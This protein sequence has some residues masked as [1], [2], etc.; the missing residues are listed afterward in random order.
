MTAPPR[1]A[2]GLW[3]G[4]GYDAELARDGAE[5]LGDAVAAFVV[6]DGRIRLLADGLV[7]ALRAAG[8][9]ERV[10]HGVAE[11][12]AATVECHADE[13]LEYVNQ[14]L[15]GGGGGGGGGGVEGGGV[16]GGA[17]G[18]NVALT[19]VDVLDA[20]LT[21]GSEG[22]FLAAVAGWGALSAALPSVHSQPSAADAPVTARLCGDRLPVAVRTM[23]GRVALPGDPA[24]TA[25]VLGDE[26]AA[27]EH[28]HR[29][30][31]IGDV[32]LLAASS[33]SLDRFISLL[34]P[35]LDALDAAA[36]GVAAAAARTDEGRPAAAAAAAAAAST[37]LCAWEAALFA[38]AAAADA[39]TCTSARALDEAVLWAFSPA[40]DPSSW[41][42]SS[43]AQWAGGGGGAPMPPAASSGDMARD[44]RLLTAAAK[45]TGDVAVARALLRAHSDTIAGLAASYAADGA[46]AAAL[47]DLLVACVA[48]ELADEEGDRDSATGVAPGSA[49]GGG[50]VDGVAVFASRPDAGG[51]GTSGELLGAAASLLRHALQDG[52]DGGAGATAVA[53]H[54]ADVAT[55]GL[56][57]LA[58]VA[59]GGVADA[60]I[61]RAVGS[62]S[63]HP[64]GHAT[65]EASND[66]LSALSKRLATRS[67]SFGGQALPADW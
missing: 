55:V 5:A 41:R 8:G 52:G 23:V 66:A 51:W 26:L 53:P 30:E 32:L 11:V 24:A 12:A 17:D 21:S 9:C 65:T 57:S 4:V 39:G 62:K 58:A 56:G 34:S 44:L 42:A 27:G 59:G 49:A 50:G 43:P 10:A 7:A 16:A 37:A 63:D 14:A 25:A 45:E 31:V 64:T 18:G 15:A 67:A 40:T 38:M 60:G 19:L 1:L 61:G 20:C 29:R 46:V 54:L 47:G 28:S 22:A 6:G 36:A 35:A 2:G 48:P 13:L 3:T 33:L